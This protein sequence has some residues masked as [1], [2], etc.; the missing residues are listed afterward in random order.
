MAMLSGLL[1]GSLAGPAGGQNWPSTELYWAPLAAAGG[2]GGSGHRL[3]AGAA[4]PL[5][6]S[7]GYDNQPQFEPGG[8]TLLFTSERAGDQTEIYRLEL[9]SGKIER[10]TDSWESEYS[11]TP[12]PGGSG[13]SV[14]RVEP[15][16]TQRLWR[17]DA[18]GGN[19][20]LILPDLS[21]VG[22]HVWGGPNGLLTFVLGDPPSLV[23]VDL[24]TGERRT[25][26]R[27]VGRALQRIPGEEAWSFVD[28][29]A[30]APV[31][32]R[33]AWADGA[34]TAIAAALSAEGEQDLAWTPDGTLLMASGSGVHA[35]VPATSSWQ[36]VR[37][38]AA[39]G[40]GAI[41]RMAVSPDGSRLVLVGAVSEERP[42]GVR[43]GEARAFLAEAESAGARGDWTTARHW[44]DRA[45]K[46]LSPQAGVERRRAVALARCG[47][48][49]EALRRLRRL[50]DW[51]ATVDLGKEA[52][53]E[54]LRALAAYQQAARR[55][56]AAKEPI[57]V[58]VL[59]FAGGPA[60][61][62]PEGIAHD[63]STG[64]FYLS[65]VRLGAVARF[66]P[67]AVSS[68]S[69]V[70]SS[71][72]DLHPLGFSSVSGI[73]VDSLRDTLW[74]VAGDLPPASNYRAERA[75]PTGLCAIDL[76]EI[77]PHQ[78]GRVRRCFS[79]GDNGPHR[80]DDLTVA[81]DGTVFVSDGGG[82]AVYRLR[83]GAETLERWVADPHL[84]APNGLALSTREDALYVADYALGLVRIDRET[85]ASRVLR[86]EL[87]PL[88][89]IDGLARWR[90]S[91]L[92]IQ[93]GVAPQRI[94]RL[95]LADGGA[96]IEAVAVLELGRTDWD[97]PTL[98][99]VVAGDFYYVSNS[100]WPRFEQ[101]GALR[102]GVP[103]SPPRILKI[104]AKKLSA[105]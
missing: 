37:D 72:A 5:A 50:A 35:W 3:E 80:F 17:F 86:T 21:G 54:P 70:E 40:V 58:A 9:A 44:L 10:L 81:A 33:L 91:L 103:L 51:R 31:V 68:P 63:P 42:A 56:E 65:S 100:H 15:D 82:A 43:H 95:D 27:R 11:P 69:I 98:G 4:Q 57:E 1:A 83:P 71:F 24:S 73:A 39:D 28:R 16:G 78:A 88:V 19:P 85:A 55:I 26:A 67:A 49:E 79:P 48:S 20:E 62:V 102:D 53:F 74:V 94:L 12:L 46:D 76:R 61:F 99:T 101:S 75:H 7:P 6:V 92:A 30:D 22:Y 2:S 41:T 84:V 90:G 29:S 38:F 60:D 52:A 47:R 23:R 14:V 66:A 96:G 59:G 104:E 77:P 93:N 34:I 89:G 25:V 13:F 36:R 87:A 97:E 45:A 105:R 8:R 18:S 64:A 32:R